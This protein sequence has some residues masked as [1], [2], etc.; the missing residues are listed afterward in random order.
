MENTNCSKQFQAL[1][2]VISEAIKHAI[3]LILSLSNN[4]QDFG[5][6][7]QN[8]NWARGAGISMINNDDDFYTNAVV[9][10]YY[11][12]HVQVQNETSINQQ[13]KYIAHSSA[14][15]YNRFFLALI[16]VMLKSTT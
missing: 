8:V 15:N 9:K 11:K 3:H 7:R 2:F 12:N 16:R 14:L 5:G 1:D 6:R 4:Y 10:G 13:L